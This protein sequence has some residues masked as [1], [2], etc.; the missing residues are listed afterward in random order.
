MSL[1]IT[2]TPDHCDSHGHHGQAIQHAIDTVSQQRGGTVHLS[3]GK[4]V[5]RGPLRVKSHVRL[6][7]EG[8]G[9]VLTAVPFFASP[10][11]ESADTGQKEVH[12]QSVDEFLPGS[13]LILLDKRN[14]SAMAKL[15]FTIQHVQNDT[16]YLNEFLTN[17]W[18]AEQDGLA[19]NYFPFILILDAHDVEIADL[20][21][22]QKRANDA[23][24]LER[25]LWGAGLYSRSSENISVERVVVENAYGDGL[26]CGSCLGVRWISCIV[27]NNTHYGVHPGSHTK[28]V[29]LEDCNIHGNGSDGVYV[30]WGVQHSIFRRNHIHGNGFRI[31]RTGF[32]IGHKDTD[33][34]VE[35]NHIHGNAK[36]G[37]HIRIKPVAN[38]A[39]RNVFRNNLIEDNGRPWSD[40]PQCL[41]DLVP[42]HTLEGAGVFINGVTRDLIFEHNTLR[43]LNGLQK[44]GIHV[45]PEVLNPVFT[46]NDI[47]GHEIDFEL[48]DPAS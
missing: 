48:T 35:G 39:H 10:L 19:L 23:V 37:I 18:G 44:R 1:T 15:P 4:Y 36:H 6:E 25:N 27:R 31:H 7:G 46:G 12:P 38:G 11:N 47:S 42:H 3:S 43:N 8:S 20:C 29:L 13:G 30:C 16:I 24:V 21:I 17:D 33:N 32:C 26:R 5:L 14:G 28:R 41:K 22:D 34:L 2:I 9:T 45:G 40:V